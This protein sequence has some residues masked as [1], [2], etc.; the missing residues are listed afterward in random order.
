MTEQ[1]RERITLE[2]IY[3][4]DQAR[5]DGLGERARQACGRPRR[6]N[7]RLTRVEMTWRGFSQVREASLARLAPRSR[8]AASERL[9]P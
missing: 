5:D 3:R 4:M 8:G 2:R 7:P 1:K 9:F 6:Q